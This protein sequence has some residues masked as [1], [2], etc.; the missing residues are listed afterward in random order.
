M[1]LPGDLVVG[2]LDRITAQT[3]VAEVEGEGGGPLLRL[4]G[5]G[6]GGRAGSVR[7][8]EG[9]GLTRLVYCN[10]DL[11]QRDLDSHMLYGFGPADSGVP[12]FTVDAADARGVVAFHVDLMPRVD[13]AT[14][15][16]Y[17]DAIFSPL[18]DVFAEV[19]GDPAFAA[20][21][22]TPKQRALMSPWML[23]N[24][25]DRSDFGRTG[26]PVRRYVD[27]WLTLVANGVGPEIEAG[28]ADTD[29]P[30]RD[31]AMRRTLFGGDVDPAWDM[32][33]AA[34][35]SEPIQILR[36]LLVGSG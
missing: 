12:H 3:G 10:L 36:D 25:L 27:W 21:R 29:L 23:A 32:A 9:G 6:G 35:G 2:T 24:R 8:F 11:P 1:S 15:G 4:S 18:D 5:V 13:L 22:L 14:H 30:T 19:A 16:P 34:V 31:A 7:L 28:L 26:V 20:A 17:L 33:A